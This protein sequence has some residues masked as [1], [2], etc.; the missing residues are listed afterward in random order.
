MF[1]IFKV[2]FFYNKDVVL[3]IT[4]H[5]VYIYKFIK[6]MMSMKYNDQ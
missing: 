3:R 1:I 2:I 4:K 6:Q 5:F